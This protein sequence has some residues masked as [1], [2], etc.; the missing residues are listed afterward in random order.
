MLI[1]GSATR[2]DRMQVVR[3]YARLAVK[4]PIASFFQ[5]PVQLNQSPVSASAD[6]IFSPLS[7]FTISF[8]PRLTLRHSSAEFPFGMPLFADS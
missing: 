3:E 4:Y 2:K 1:R 6:E 5:R 7:C 8:C